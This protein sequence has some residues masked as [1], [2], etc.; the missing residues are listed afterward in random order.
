MKARD[1][2]GH[3]H[4]IVGVLVP[5]RLLTLNVSRAFTCL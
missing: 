2:L 4:S 3:M 5:R 1:D